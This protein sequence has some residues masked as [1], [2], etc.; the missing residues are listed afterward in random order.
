MISVTSYLINTIH[1][2]QYYSYFSPRLTWLAWFA[3][4]AWGGWLAWLGE[5]AL[6]C[7]TAWNIRVLSG[8]YL[9]FYLMGQ[10]TWPGLALLARLSLL[11]DLAGLPGLPAWSIVYNSL[12]QL[13]KT[14]PLRLSC[15]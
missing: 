15:F 13:K 5:G 1:E 8:N 7:F 10:P 11:A 14:S 2:L 6:A 9:G 3:Q 4:L 12:H